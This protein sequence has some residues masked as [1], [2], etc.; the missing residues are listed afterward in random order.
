MIALI[1]RIRGFSERQATILVIG[2]LLGFFAGAVTVSLV[3]YAQG[4]PANLWQWV[5]GFAQ[6][7]GTEMFGAF[8][9]FLLFDR[10]VGRRQRHAEAKEK[11]KEDQLNA[12]TRLRQADT[13]EGRQAV[14]DEMRERDL[15]KEA[16]LSNTNLREA[17]LK[18]ADLSGAILS[19][20]ILI[21]ANLIQAA[22][23]NTI[24]I[25]VNLSQASLR[26]ANLN[27]V[28]LDT[29]TLNGANLT[30]ASLRGAS[31]KG[32]DLLDAALRNAVLCD[33][34]LDGAILPDGTSWTPE[35]DMGRFT[36]PKHP[37][38]FEIIP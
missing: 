22:L 20:A 27:R 28:I 35:V 29:S 8:L 15:F 2:L 23:N 37:D 21:G 9:T 3:A 33:A 4:S 1:R 18:G 26:G 30:G 24:L 32:A 13:K 14:L 16:D 11:F 5:D 10:L 25:H 7:F 19:D 38:F 34:I 6:N 12:I 31:L 36:D 17:N